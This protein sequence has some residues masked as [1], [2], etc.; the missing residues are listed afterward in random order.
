M[1]IAILS[2]IHCNCFALSAV[3]QEVQAEQPDQIWVLGDTFGYYPWAP[4]TYRILIS[5]KQLRLVLLGNHDKLLLDTEPPLPVPSYWNVARQ[6][7][8]LLERNAPKALLW[9]QS[10]FPLAR[11][12]CQDTSLLC[13]HGTPED[14]LQGRFYP[15]NKSSPGWFPKAGEILLM[16][17]T[18]YPFARYTPEGGLVANP[19]SVGQPRDGDIRSSWALLSLPDISIEFRRTAWDVCSTVRLLERRNWYPTA[20]NALRKTR[21][22]D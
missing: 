14:P 1:R 2:D 6:N 7:R 18:H 20:I 17:H 13:V 19:G 22:A 3:L 9:L 10:L 12:T 15:D 8:D 21:R 4:E 11:F 5:T 16:G